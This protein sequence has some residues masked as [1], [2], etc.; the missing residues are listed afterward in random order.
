MRTPEAGVSA[1]PV[2]DKL[3]FK[4][5]LIHFGTTAGSH[6]GAWLSYAIAVVA[7]FAV[8]L[9]RLGLGSAFDERP[10]LIIFVLPIIVSAH[11]GGLGPGLLSTALSVGCISYFITPPQYSFSITTSYDLIQWLL[12]VVAGVLI[13][14]LNE[15]LQRSRRREA[16]NQH[17]QAAT[18]ASLAD[19]VVAYDAEGRAIFL[20]PA[21]T[22]VFGWEAEELLGQHIPFVPEDQRQASAEV[23][24][25]LYETGDTATLAT[26][27]LTKDGRLLDVVVSA[28]AVPDQSGLPSGMVVNITDVTETKHLEAQLRQAQKMEAIGTLAGGIAHDFNNILAA[29]MGYTEIAQENAKAGRPNLS[30]LDRVMEAI[31]RA[32]GLVQRI[33]TF[34]R[35][36]DAE[37]KPLNLNKVVQQ[38]LQLL[39][40]SLP[41]M[42][43]IETQ[44]DPALELINADP[45]QLEQIIMNLATNAADAMPEGGKL[46]L[47]T[48]N[49]FLDAE[50]CRS[51]LEVTPGQYVL[52]LVS[53]N[54]QGIEP[55]VM[56][57]IFDPFFTTKPVGKGTGLGLSTVFGIVKGHGGQI[58]CY[59]EPGLGTTFRIY[60]TAHQSQQAITEAASEL[61]DKLPRGTE[62]VLLVDD[63]QALREIGTRTLQEAGYRV[64]TA[65][66]GE[67]ALETYR[68]K[69]GSIDLVIMDLGM[70]G[71]GGHKCLLELMAMA[72]RARVIIAS[73]YAAN[74]PVK[75]CLE[76]GAVGYV[77][78]PFRRA[79]LLVTVRQILDSS[80]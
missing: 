11:W 13:S 36:T 29:M 68:A 64:L 59:S 24:A 38:A 22:R 35:R 14:V 41:K 9:I 66:S 40:P 74:G 42:I 33:L 20:N 21:F 28:A 46:V 43:T 47:E 60:L 56:E 80:C 30:E 49:V 12:L 44:L 54:G 45:T 55:Q 19:P 62:T 27:R 67:E 57:H 31:E 4:N 10:L 72:P 37:S 63:E 79:D 5:N 18:L 15:A 61:T 77:A 39:E 23:I 17:L 70:P 34:S 58:Y 1:A 16:A 2:S 6:R 50:Y 76:S 8:L 25:R 51:H 26:K 71:M 3:T 53:D 32:R 7:T 78:K 69:G 65:S 52:L 75:T 48:T 73:G